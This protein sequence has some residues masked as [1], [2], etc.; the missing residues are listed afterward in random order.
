[1]DVVFVIVT[2]RGHGGPD[3][4]TTVTKG[5]G[6]KKICAWLQ[7]SGDRNGEA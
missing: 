2:V 7:A 1:V 3:Q 4:S 6:V 5:F